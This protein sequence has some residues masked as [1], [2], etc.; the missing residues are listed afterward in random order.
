[1]NARHLTSVIPSAVLAFA[2]MTGIAAAKDYQRVVPLLNDSKTILG[3]P[4]AYPSKG[5]PKIQS[6]IVTMLPGEETGPHTHPYPTY[7][8]I[9]EGELTV[10]YPGGIKKVYK[11]GEA[12]MEAVNA[13][14]N[15]KN[16]GS[17]PVRIL[18]VFMGVADQANTLLPEKD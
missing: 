13:I 17:E 15:G 2:L 14:H 5:T 6:V 3:Q 12:V 8:Y 11:K 4:L 10:S 7:G 9:L 1:M 18:V 16:T